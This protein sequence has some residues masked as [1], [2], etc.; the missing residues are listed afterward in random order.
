MWLCCLHTARLQGFS[1]HVDMLPF[2]E[3]F[4]VIWINNP[5]NLVSIQYMLQLIFEETNARGV[6]EK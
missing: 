4:K 6:K 2:S 1:V 5:N 3:F